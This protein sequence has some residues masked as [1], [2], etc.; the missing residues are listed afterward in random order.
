MAIQSFVRICCAIVGAIG[1]LENEAFA[2]S[3]IV[4]DGTLGGERSVVT[5]L[6]A[7][8]NLPIDSITQGAQRG[9]NL[10]HSFK[11]FNV[12]PGRG[13]YFFVPDTEVRNI[14]TRVTG[15]IRSDI[16]GTI[17]TF[18]PSDSVLR[19]PDVNVFLINPNGVVFG[20]TANLD[21][22]GSLLVTTANAVQLGANGL[23]SAS[24]PIESNLLSVNPSTFLFNAIGQQ[25]E[26]VNQ[27]PLQLSPGQSIILLGGNIRL[28]QGSIQTLGGRVEIGGLTTQG[29]V[30]LSNQSSLSLNFL[31]QPSNADIDLNQATIV[32]SGP[33]SG[34]V[35]IQG[36]LVT[37]NK[38]SQI[39]SIAQ[40]EVTGADIFIQA[41]Q[42]HL[43]EASAI[44]AITVGSGAG[45]NL[46]IDVK[47]L[48][49]QDASTL[50]TAT[51]VGQGKAG[52]LNLR[53][54]ESIQLSSNSAISSLAIGNRQFETTG[55]GGDVTIVTKNL[56]VDEAGITSNAFLGEGRGGNLTVEASDSVDLINGSLSVNSYGTGSGG[57]LLIKTGNLT[58]QDSSLV[59]TSSFNP[60]GV[61]Q[62]NLQSPLLSNTV[63]QNFIQ[64]V[65][66][67]I[68]PNLLGN[69]NSGN[70]T[71]MATDT[72]KIEG[73]RNGKEDA[74]SLLSTRTSGFG[75][76]GDLTIQ[77]RRLLI[78]PGGW[79]S[80][81]AGERS[82]GKGGNLTINASES[83]EIRG[84]LEGNNS[85]LLSSLTEGSGDSGN[86]SI[87]AKS[88]ILSGGGKIASESRSQGNAGEI[89]INL[90]DS[91]N[92]SA[93]DISSVSL[94]SSGGLID[95]TARDIRLNNDSDIKTTVLGGTGSGGNINLTARSIVAFNDSDIL[96][97]ARDGKG[98]NVT[99]N[100]RAFF[101][102]NYRPAPLGTNPASLDGNDRV[103]INAS[104]SLASGTITRPDTSFIQNSLNQ[105]PTGAIDTTKLLANTCI[106]RK[107]KLEGTFYITGTGGLPNRPG[108]LSPS[109]YPTNSIAP[110]Q[111]ATRPWQKGD[112]IEEPTGFYTLAN[113][114]LVMSRECQF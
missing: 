104:G 17:G 57:D 16:F 4:P 22:G 52:D 81:D 102:Q 95:I 76:A 9:Q 89:R 7:T 37:L 6:D 66:I 42:L 13:A 87:N 69:V 72:I 97:F 34:I 83:I 105:L 63:F 31:E 50:T 47:R 64:S 85:A 15:T 60:K 32:L 65:L 84:N 101:G 74:V 12:A 46:T 27:A 112:P 56:K 107:D 30:E 67:G 92:S 99:L 58:L 11:D 26:I 54:S 86:I 18:R 93:S 2:Q 44:G 39:T 45:G 19:V 91:F 36:R 94:K 106:V 38:G 21:I 103:D 88:L 78:N 14:L 55:S 113:G 43:N 29:R 28:D 41:N 77:T 114:R 3:V 82:T 90:Q 10:F 79:I 80:T 70:I 40:D 75:K 5:P 110:I 98:G 108:D 33:G 59:L 100:T 109:Q 23:F 25:A 68:D 20:K 51:I 35:K 111:T 96:A 1:F 73:K 53:A 62:S 8:L 49:L 61:L 24:Q 48:N 71:I